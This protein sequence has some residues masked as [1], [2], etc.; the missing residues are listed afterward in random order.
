M[1]GDLLDNTSWQEGFA[2]LKEYGMSFDSQLNPPQFQKAALFFGKHPDI[3]VIINHMGCPT[4]ADLSDP[5]RRKVF[6]DGMAALAALP[7]VSIKISMLV[8]TD[9]KWDESA[10]VVD[11]VKSVIKL[12]GC[13]RCMFASN[14]PVDSKD[15]WNANRLMTAFLKLVDDMSIADKKNIFA[16][17]AKRIY[18]V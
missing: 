16:E 6:D 2:L 4:L 3:P 9:P 8:Y 5:D 14:F 7:H 18:R 11:A 13:D 15:G 10:I 12:F 1:L 17:N